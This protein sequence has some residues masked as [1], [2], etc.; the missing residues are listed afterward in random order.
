MVVRCRLLLVSTSLLTVPTDLLLIFMI[1]EI[2]WLT[3]IL[4]YPQYSYIGIFYGVH[5]QKPYI[6]EGVMQ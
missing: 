5:T 2:S 3:L 1:A 4:F 6:V